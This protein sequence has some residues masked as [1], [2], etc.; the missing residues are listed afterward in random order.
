MTDRPIPTEIKLLQKERILKLHF[1]NGQQYTLPC[2]Y[3]RVFSP[4]AEVRRHGNPVLVTG[5]QAVNI[6]GIDPVGQ[7]AVRLI[8]DDGH[9]TGIYSWDYLYELGKSQPKNWQ[10][11]LA[12]LDQDK[13]LL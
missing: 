8:F 13:S 10:A 11:Y 9:S 12:R 3:L 5:K 6:V 2:E 7:Y 4:S 1:D